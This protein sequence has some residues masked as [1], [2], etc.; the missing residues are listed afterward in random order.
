MYANITKTFWML[1]LDTSVPVFHV[2]YR[3]SYA[4]IVRLV[5]NSERRPA[6]PGIIVKLLHSAEN[7]LGVKYYLK[8]KK[9]I[10]DMARSLV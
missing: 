2:Q 5:L 10:K 7:V 4:T 8:S 3:E 1:R 9:L 6:V